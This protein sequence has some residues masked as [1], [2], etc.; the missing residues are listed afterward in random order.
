[1]KTQIILIL[2]FLFLATTINAQNENSIDSIFKLKIEQS[3]ISSGDNFPDFNIKNN[4]L[5][6]FLYAL[7]KGYSPDEFQSYVKINN[8]KMSNIK[9][10][11]M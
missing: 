8:E 10:G 6:R 7:H 9:V 1:M 2:Y 11:I 5:D 3:C 4:S